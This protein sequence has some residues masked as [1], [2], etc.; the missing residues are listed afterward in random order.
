MDDKLFEKSVTVRFAA[1]GK[2]QR[3]RF[4]HEASALL[5]S[6]DWPGKGRRC[7]RDAF[8][9]AEKV[10][11]GDRSTEDARDRFVEAAREAGILVE[12]SDDEGSTPKRIYFES[13]VRIQP[14]GGE[15]VREVKSVNG[16]CEAL[17]DWPHAKRGPY[18]QSGREILEGTIQ[19]K[20][21]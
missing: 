2:I 14:H 18:Y 4:A 10:L 9:T 11:E 5:A 1:D 3:V 16:A 15:T 7:I 13:S 21:K 6:S 17:I 20:A 12:P 8:E 19:A